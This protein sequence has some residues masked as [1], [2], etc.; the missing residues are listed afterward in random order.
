M[1]TITPPGAIV[2]DVWSVNPTPVMQGS[3][4]GG[5]PLFLTPADLPYTF[6]NV[7]V[8]QAGGLTLDVTIDLNGGGTDTEVTTVVV[9]NPGVGYSAGQV[10]TI[11]GTQLFAGADDD[12]KVRINQVGDDR[13]MVKVV[14]VDNTTIKLTLAA[15]M[16]MWA[17]LTLPRSWSWR[18]I[19]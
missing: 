14:D 10:V 8:L 2:G 19:R 16:D 7:P 5:P 18:S 12:V 11:D 4:Y 3:G 1:F 15:D 13:V 9:N 17:R 6:T